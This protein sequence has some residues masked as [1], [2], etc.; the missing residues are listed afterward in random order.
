MTGSEPGPALTANP[1]TAQS[2][3]PGDG[4]TATWEMCTR[5]VNLTWDLPHFRCT[6][7]KVKLADTIYAYIVLNSCCNSSLAGIATFYDAVAARILIFNALWLV[8][9]HPFGGYRGVVIDRS[10]HSRP[11]HFI[12][13]YVVDLDS[14]STANVREQGVELEI[15]DRFEY[16]GG[17]GDC[18]RKAVKGIVGKTYPSLDPWRRSGGRRRVG[19]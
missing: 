6:A 13:T 19:R 2:P 11:G 1:P 16:E 7:V 17:T 5:F 9:N 3:C 14:L 12:S 18:P 8:L 10:G 4:V 15:W